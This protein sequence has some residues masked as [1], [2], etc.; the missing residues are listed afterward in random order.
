MMYEENYHLASIGKFFVTLGYSC[1][2]HQ[3]LVRELRAMWTTDNRDVGFGLY[4]GYNKAAVLKH[5]LSTK[6]LKNII[7]KTSELSGGNNIA[8]VVVGLHE[9][10]FPCFILKR[11][12]SLLWL[13]L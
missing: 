3:L 12:L 9:T 1:C 10:N 13:F 5:N 7:F 2:R 11:I 6:V 8:Y 4:E